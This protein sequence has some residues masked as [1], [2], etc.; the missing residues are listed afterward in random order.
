MEGFYV[1]RMCLEDCSKKMMKE[2][3]RG[4][5]ARDGQVIK[6][7]IVIALT[8]RNIFQLGELVSGLLESGMRG[9]IFSLMYNS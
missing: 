7:F 6:A 9:A 1:A 8:Y 5:N 2:S 3:C 4:L